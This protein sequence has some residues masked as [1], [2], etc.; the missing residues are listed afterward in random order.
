MIRETP[1]CQQAG[2]VGV[3]QQTRLMC[4]LERTGVFLR[5][6]RG[7]IVAMQW[8]VV[9]FYS[10]LVV[11]PV[12]FPMPARSGAHIWDNLRLF[13][14]FVFWG[15]WWPGVMLTTVFLGRVW[16]GFFCPEGYLSELASRHGRGA[17][18]PNWIKW[19]TWPFAAFIITT[20]YG[21][22]ISVYEYSEAALLILGGST[23]AAVAIGLIYGRGRRVWCR[24][25]CP[26]SGVFAVL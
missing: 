21:Q 10:A 6:H 22:L 9:L 20:V 26:A 1:L 11:L 18:T 19:P 13:A 15:L 4:A 23:L 12:F 5:R 17:A 16:C 14:Q 8:C 7:F 2:L 24:Y 3:F 25:L